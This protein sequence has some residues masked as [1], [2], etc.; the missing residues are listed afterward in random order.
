MI[1]LLPSYDVGDN[2]YAGRYVDESVLYHATFTTADQTLEYIDNM[3]INM[4]C[5]LSTEEKTM[6][7]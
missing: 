6:K 4:K 5:N 2:I 1:Y 3:P 7:S